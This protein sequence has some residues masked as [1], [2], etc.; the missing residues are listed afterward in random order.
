MK[1]ILLFTTVCI[2]VSCS[3]TKE[4]TLSEN[5]RA[6][7]GEYST[8]GTKTEKPATMTLYDFKVTDINGKEFDMSSLKG[9]KVLIVNTAS[10]CG[11]TPQYEQLE[12]IYKEY[13]GAKFEIIGFPANNFGGQEPGT[14]TEIAAFCSK[15]YGVTFRMMSKISVI[16][17]DQHEIYQ[18]LTQKSENG[19][20]DAEVKWN[21]HKFLID[22]NGVIVKS[23]PHKTS[24][25][26]PIILDWVKGE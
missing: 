25:D 2:F 26:D 14:D 12:K 21:F 9:K 18:W 23:V 1:A 16:G 22:E 3:S 20:M 5:G 8:V 11:Y 24:P 10:E 13:G 19:V 17:E 6:A 4:N 7:N 15:N